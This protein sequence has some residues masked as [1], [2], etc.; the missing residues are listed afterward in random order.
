MSQDI[1]RRETSSSTTE[2]IQLPGLASLPQ[3]LIKLV[4]FEVVLCR[5]GSYRPI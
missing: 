4:G 1:V 3:N 5:L 2:I